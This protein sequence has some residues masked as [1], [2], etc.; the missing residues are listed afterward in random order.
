MPFMKYVENIA[1]PKRSHNNNAVR[2]RKDAIYVP[3]SQGKSTDTDS[4]YL[5]LIAS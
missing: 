5:I 3:D 2:R 4:K 1:A